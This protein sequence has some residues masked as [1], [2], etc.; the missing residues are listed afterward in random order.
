MG[1]GDPGEGSG[2]TGPPRPSRRP[3][4]IVNMAMSADGKISSVERRQVRISGSEDRERV[5]RLKAGCD[6]VMVGIGTVLADNPSLT[7]K[8]DGL[9]KERVRAGRPENPVRIVI[10]SRG[11]T[12]PGA[13]ILRKGAGERII[14]VSERAG[15]G[16]AA[17]FGGLATVIV[18]GKEEVDLPLLMAGLHERGIG[19]LM[20][21]GGGSLVSSLFAHGLVDEFYTFVGN[22]IIG[23]K[24]APTPVDGQGFPN[25]NTFV[26][27]SLMD[28]GELGEGVLLRWRVKNRR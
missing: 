10:D 21:E 9:K 17:R 13:D 12:P 27:L 5:D 18:A 20:V 3:Y 11:R 26:S 8:S 24:E 16:A 1:N 6:A 14:A 28:V 23:G 2:E 19:R 7:V 22:L 15:K 4:T 25:D